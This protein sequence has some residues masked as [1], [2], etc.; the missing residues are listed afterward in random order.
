MRVRGWEGGREGRRGERGTGRRGA[1]SCDCVAIVFIGG[2][3]DVYWP[4]LLCRP[5]SCNVAESPMICAS[6]ICADS[7]Y[8]A[9]T[10]RRRERSRISTSE[11]SAQQG[12][13]VYFYTGLT[14]RENFIE[15]L[16]FLRMPSSEYVYERTFNWGKECMG[17]RQYRGKETMVIGIQCVHECA[18][19]LNI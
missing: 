18:C 13:A 2:L 10:G 1:R 6:D 19:T 7:S 17:K 9:W 8:A 4:H 3:D 5:R 12:M 11:V 14:S 15:G 16:V